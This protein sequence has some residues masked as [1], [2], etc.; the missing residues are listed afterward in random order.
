MEKLFTIIL[1]IVFF[2]FLISHSVLRN[3][4]PHLLQL[5]STPFTLTHLK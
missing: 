4:L 1:K 2:E 3:T 5:I